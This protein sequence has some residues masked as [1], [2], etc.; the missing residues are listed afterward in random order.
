MNF[1]QMGILKKKVRVATISFCSAA[2]LNF[3]IKKLAGNLFTV[4]HHGIGSQSAFINSSNSLCC[5]FYEES[6]E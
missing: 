4:Q 1:N 6:Q 5:F 2:M 3:L